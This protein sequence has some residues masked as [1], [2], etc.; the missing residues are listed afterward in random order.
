[1]NKV[2]LLRRVV[3]SGSRVLSPPTWV[4]NPSFHIF[5]FTYLLS[6]ESAFSALQAAALRLKEEA[7]S[8]RM[9][10]DNWQDWG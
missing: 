4:L 5:F 7:S 9:T 6:L 1:M 3:N 10:A 2:C 8:L